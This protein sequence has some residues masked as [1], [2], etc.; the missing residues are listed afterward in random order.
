P[1]AV[2][3]KSEP[4]AAYEIR[5]ES[6]AATPMAI[7]AAR[8]LTPLVG[9]NE[10]LAQ[11]QACFR[12]LE[13]SQAQVVAVVG[14][15]G[16]GKSRLLYEFRRP[17]EGAPVIFFEGRCSAL[18]APYFPFINMLQHYFGLVRWATAHPACATI[19]AKARDP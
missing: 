14:D 18:A 1:H 11:L 13:R 9:R 16:L 19:S 6:A 8:G 3:G 12:R 10:E 5:G 17:L 2:K 7:V 15:A 4:V